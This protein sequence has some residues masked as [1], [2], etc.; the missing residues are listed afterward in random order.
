MKIGKKLL[1]SFVFIVFLF[2]TIP[3]L[4]F[5]EDNGYAVEIYKRSGSKFLVNN[6]T[7][8]GS[9]YCSK[10]LDTFFYDKAMNKIPFKDVASVEFKGR[11]WIRKGFPWGNYYRKAVITY[12]DGDTKRKTFALDNLNGFTTSGEWTLKYNEWDSMDSIVFKKWGD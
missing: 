11:T 10:T 9:I 1:I 4:C 5:S 3:C 8:G 7:L 12:K 2:S 6:F